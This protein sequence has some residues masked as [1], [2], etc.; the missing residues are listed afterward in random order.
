MTK[1]R[2]SDCFKC[3]NIKDNG[4]SLGHK[5]RVYKDGVIKRVCSD[6][7]TKINIG[8]ADKLMSIFGFFRKEK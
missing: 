6:F 8:M 3:S 4:C 2:A 5:P 1:K 7:S